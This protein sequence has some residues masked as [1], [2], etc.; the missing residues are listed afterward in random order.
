MA[1]EKFED[2]PLLAAAWI[3]TS[4]GAVDMGTF[5]AG[6]V[7]SVPSA[8]LLGAGV[9]EVLVLGY[10]AAGAVALGVDLMGVT[11]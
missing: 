2:Q 6:L 4:I 11:E 3:G 1:L 8:Q 10:I 7:E 9:S 5:V